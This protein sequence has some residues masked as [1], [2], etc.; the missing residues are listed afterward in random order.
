MDILSSLVGLWEESGFYALFVGD[1]WQNLIM[2]LIAC[3]LLFL[4][5]AKKFE[6]LLLV[7]IAFGMLLTNLPNSAVYTPEFWVGDQ[8]VA[9]GVFVDIYRCWR[10]DGLWSDAFKTE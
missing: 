5:I 8:A 6:P 7:G 3:L 4:G 10:D 1:G 2:I 9:N